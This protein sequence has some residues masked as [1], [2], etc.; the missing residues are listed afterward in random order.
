MRR[1]V[2]LL[3]LAGGA[4]AFWMSAPMNN[5]YPQD[6]FQP[7][8]AFEMRLSGT[9]GELRPNHFHS[10]IDIKSSQGRIGDPVLAAGDGD[11]MRISVQPGG[12]GKALYLRHP[13]GYTSVYAHLDSFAPEIEA[14]VKE[15]QYRLQSFRVNLF[16]P[17]GRFRYRRGEQIGVLGN[18]GSSQGPHLHF[19]IRDSRTEKPINPLLF[20]LRIS[21]DR[22][23]RMHQLKV[24]YLN[25]KRETLRS[26]TFPLF[27]EGERYRLQ[28]DTLLIG[29]WR[30]GFGLKV[31]DHHNNVSNWNGIYA[32][33]LYQDGELVYRF[34]AEAFSFAE[35]R[36]INAHMDYPERVARRSYFHRCYKLPGNRLSLYEATQNDGVVPLYRNRPSRIEIVAEDAYGN[37]ARLEFWVRRGEVPPAETPTYNYFF[38]YDE[39]NIID[40]HPLFVRLPKGALYE[41]L[42]LQ[43]SVSA[44]V[45]E[46]VSEV[47]HLGDYSTPVH[48]YFQI[49]IRPNRKLSR[50]EMQKAFVAYVA[51]NGNLV[52]CGGKWLDG[53]IYARVRGLG[54]YCILLDEQPPTI[55]P[56]SFRYDMRGRSKMTFRLT[57]NFDTGGKARPIAYKATVDGEWILMELDAKNDLLIHRFDERIPPGEHLLRI[58]AMDNRGNRTVFQEKFRR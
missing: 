7:P 55:Q 41:N 13:N 19:E 54:P 26:R 56:R 11:V 35:T 16:P 4:M 48:Q 33:S 14:Y 8:V 34:R 17:V 52:N 10:G 40:T 18:S 29:A 51:P 46:A 22:P 36:F 15:Q 2:A 28:A 39:E 50:E 38:P 27:R 44:D 6:F 43:Y 37:A 12:Y 49:G 30:A 3:I 58:E 53:R 5:P 23:P 47:H 21:D 20:G 9:F 31:Y 45:P 42:Y 1:F 25:E 57:D 32:L 24:Y